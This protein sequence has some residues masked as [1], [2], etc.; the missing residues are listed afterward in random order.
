MSIVIWEQLG[1]KL[2]PTAVTTVYP[3][4]QN[5]LLLSHREDGDLT[6]PAFPA[7]PDRCLMMSS[8]PAAI[9]SFTWR[10]SWGDTFFGP[11]LGRETSN[12][13]CLRET[14]PLIFYW[15]P[16][17]S[18]FDGVSFVVLSIILLQ[19]SLR[20]VINSQP[21][22]LLSICNLL[23]SSYLLIAIC[24]NFFTSCTLNKLTYSKPEIWLS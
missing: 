24:Y 21:N 14:A 2:L 11:G 16:V 4:E 7:H 19:S 3:I 22:I 6:A 15:I 9:C 12:W 8:P 5:S 1:S 20:N 18:R 17:G 13:L 10:P 23:S